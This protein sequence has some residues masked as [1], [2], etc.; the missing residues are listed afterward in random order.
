M[1]C[2]GQSTRETSA[3]I[4]AADELK[5][6][7]ASICER[8]GGGLDSHVYFLAARKLGRPLLARERHSDERQ[9]VGGAGACLKRIVAVTWPYFRS[10]PCVRR[11]GACPSSKSRYRKRI[12]WQW[13]RDD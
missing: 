3:L 5:H 13:R 4:I 12:I 2:R 11:L 8:H 7:V 9:I 1:T 10:A 6:G